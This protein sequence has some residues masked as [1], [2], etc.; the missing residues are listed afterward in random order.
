L[1][2]AKV[3]EE[4]YQAFEM[5]YPVLQDFKKVWSLWRFASAVWSYI[6]P[7]PWCTNTPTPLVQV[8]RFHDSRNFQKLFA[9]G[10]I[11]PTDLTHYTV[12]R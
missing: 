7:L 9:F 10:D 5:I 1:T 2:G 12:L 3:R 6:P 11:P 8:L 4:I